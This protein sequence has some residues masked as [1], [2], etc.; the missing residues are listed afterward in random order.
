M[1]LPP[2]RETVA[3]RNGRWGE[4]VAVEHLRANGY[5]IV[6]RNARPCRRDRRL[7]IDIVAYDRENDV[8]VFVE[9]KQ[10]RSHS[11][12]ERRLRS[13]DRRKLRLMRRV[14]SAWLK[15]NRWTGARRFD[16]V[17]VFGEPGGGR[18]EVDHVE[19][20]RLFDVRERFVNWDA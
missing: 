18:A 1:P 7:E 15:A 20:I 19:R 17:E 14:C 2:S 5:V 16:V 11:Q 13:V 6:D 10:H 8:M 9:V 12:R 4:D 3:E